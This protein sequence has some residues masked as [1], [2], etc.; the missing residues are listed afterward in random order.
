MTSNRSMHIWERQPKSRKYL[1]AALLLVLAG[2][3]L[4]ACAATRQSGSG[5][6]SA[7]SAV[8]PSATDT[9][10][11]H[12]K[13]CAMIAQIDASMNAAK[14]Q[15]Q[16]IAALRQYQSQFGE[17][18]SLAPANEKGDTETVVHATQQLLAGNTPSDESSAATAAHELDSYCNLN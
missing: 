13:F 3:F 10:A 15:D 11:N 7:N 14:T 8:V 17:L 16:K 1:V 6:Q 2:A 5:Q 18:V 9:A 12:P 4:T